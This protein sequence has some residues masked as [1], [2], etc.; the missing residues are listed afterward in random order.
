VAARLL[1]AIALVALLAT[2]WAC[3]PSGS[4]LDR[5]HDQAQQLM[6]RGQIDDALAAA[7]R[8]ASLSN[9]AADDVRV[10]RFRLLVADARLTRLEYPAAMSVLEQ[11]IPESPE[12]APLRGRQR[13][14]LARA[15]V[16]QGQLTAA[17]PLMDEATALAGSDAALVLD[18]ELLRSQ[19][20][21]R[22]GRAAEADTL[23][24]GARQRT[25]ASGDRYRLAQVSN[26]IGLGLVTRGRYDEALPYFNGVIGDR[27]LQGTTVQGNAF[28][29]AGICH[30]RLGQFEKAVALQQQAIRIQERG[31]KQN[32][33]QALG[34]LGS[35]YLLQED[36]AQ[37]A[38]YLQ[39]AFTI[40]AEAG[41]ASDAALFARNLAGAYAV[42][43][44]WAEAARF[45]G[46][47]A[48]FA[49]GT[50]AASPYA[51]VTEA[52][53]ASGRGQPD[54]AS[55]L[56]TKA[57][58]DP[59]ATPG[60]RWMSH[61]GLARLAT[62]SGKSAEAAREFESALQIVEQTRSSLLRSDDRIS[63][64]SRLLSFYRGYVE[65][66]LSQNQVE[67]ALEVAD[68][69]RARVLAER[70]GVA[71]P[72]ARAKAASLRQL[73]RAT[74]STLLFYW[75][76]QQQSWV[77]TVTGEQISAT[78]LPPASRIEALV[79]E[80]QAAI[81][82][83]LADPLSAPGSAG[84][85]LYRTVVE[86][87]SQE[88]AR[89]RTVVIVPD[90]ALHRLNFETLLVPDQGSVARHYWLEDVTVQIAPSLAMLEPA[91]AGAAARS[92]SSL[93]L[94]GNAP[95]RA[96]EFP[97]LSY[98]PAE[99]AAV[100]KH[101]AP[102][103]VSVFD[104]EHASPAAFRSAAPERFSVIHFT[105]HAVA[106]A[107][108]PLDS[109]VILSGPDDSYKLYARDVAGLPLTAELVTVSACRS[110]GE[111]AYAGEG[112]V[113]FAWAFLRGGSRRVVAGLWDVDDRST[114]ALMEGLYA[115]I[116]AGASPPVALREAK[117]ALIKNGYAKPY[118]W[119][120]FQLFTV[121]I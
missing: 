120:P 2:G 54:E 20:L 16:S 105:S 87:V 42:L 58:S 71:P 46:E 77:W 52:R 98:A 10:W 89:H 1:R 18:I 92:S 19:W 104:G 28:N 64:T 35:T 8:G 102:T 22:S 9:E 78:E 66:L 94:V 101:F 49:E 73:A 103:A 48:T 51:I 26:N 108:S 111:R 109:A 116:A 118:Y 31:R 99:M 75:L 37:G 32:H 67:R 114:A 69:S 93:L 57:L 95:A 61:E 12:F 76:G 82:N 79:A 55:R 6:R 80:H 113:G 90:G 84:E 65:L 91:P 11:T 13:L 88:A 29:N 41:L 27:E 33:A 119:A 106:N 15:K 23:L 121:V 72:A 4:S 53:I 24:A 38:E 56:F 100:R 63:F 21:Y 112:L 50:G 43:G 68:A 96:P 107:E 3:A 45:S 81:Q 7:E 59:K 117:R 86:P 62:I 110:A 34:E 14:M 74:G 115:R 97:A 44:R 39:R 17:Q 40:A 83:A 36:Y 30:A 70:Q 5:L 47:A 60:V 25:A 85:Q